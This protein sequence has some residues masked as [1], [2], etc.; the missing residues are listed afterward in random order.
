MLRIH[1]IQHCFN[2]ANLAC[3]E[4]LYDSASLRRF[5]GIEDVSRLEAVMTNAGHFTDSNHSNREI[6]LT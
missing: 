6:P 5:L 2:L 4:A 3:E 1:F